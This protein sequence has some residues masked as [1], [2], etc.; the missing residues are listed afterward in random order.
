MDAIRAALEVGARRATSGCSSPGIDVAA[1]GN[2]FGLTRG[3]HDQFGDRVRDTPISESA[4]I[5]LGVGAA[6]AGMRPVVEL[7]YLDF[8]GV[9]LD[10]LLNQAAKLPFMTG[11]A[12]EMALTVRTQ[13]GAGRSSGSQHSQSLEALLAHIPGLTVVMPSTPADTYGLLRAAIQDPNPVV[14]IENRLLYGMKGPQPPADHVVP[15]GTSV[16]VRPGTDITVVS[17]SRM[18]HEAVA[19]AERLAGEGIS[20]EVIDLRTVAPLDM[21]PILES[22]H[23]T[24]RLADRARGGR[25]VRHRRRDRGHRRARG[26]LGPRRADRTYRR[27]ADAPALRARARTRVA[28]R[29]RRHRRR[30]PPP[31]RHLTCFVSSRGCAR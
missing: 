12:A 11:G 4:I 10:Q 27:R 14:F 15:I 23:K 6:M 9:C 30:H 18:V 3:L 29:P 1:G 5:G 7:M 26:L 13:F 28:P 21:A 19:A 20:V 17:V 2:V 24:S 31:R 8:L 16:V 25:A 22:V